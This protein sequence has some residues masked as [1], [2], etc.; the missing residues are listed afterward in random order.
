MG[1]AVT[2]E[3]ERNMSEFDCGWIE[4]EICDTCKWFDKEYGVCRHPVGSKSFAD[5]GEKDWCEQWTSK[6]E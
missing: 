4:D 6:F 3:K 1:K 2:G 5:V